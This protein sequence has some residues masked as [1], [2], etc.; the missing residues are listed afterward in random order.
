MLKLFF[1]F[2]VSFTSVNIYAEKNIQFVINTTK[3]N[4]IIK[5]YPNKAPITVKN[6]ENYVNKGFYNDT[7]FHRVIDGFMIQGGGFTKDMSQKQT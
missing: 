1:I 7:I 4:I 6:F 3:G 5:T 2:L